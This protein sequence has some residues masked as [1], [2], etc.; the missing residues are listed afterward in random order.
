M[1]EPID[2]I[3]RSCPPWRRGDRLTECGLT[4]D[5]HPT[6]TRAAAIAKIKE[7]GIQRASL[8]LCMT[9][10]NTADRWET[11]EANPASCINRETDHYRD[12]TQPI[13][14]ELRAIAAL[15]AAH[16]DEFYDYLAGLAETTSLDERRQAKR[17]R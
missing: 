14:A 10:M 9:C 6:L 3:E 1:I 16:P 15:I 8:F 12:K 4:A 11:W 7:M 13:H 2:H 17:R 5:N